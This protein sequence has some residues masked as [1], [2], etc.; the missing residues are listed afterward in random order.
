M[1]G[2]AF[3]DV[4]EELTAEQASFLVALR[5]RLAEGVRP[6]FAGV[7][8]DGMN[9]ILDVDA[10]DVVSVTVG[11]ALRGNQLKGDR[12]S[13]HHNGFPASPTGDGFLVEGST[14]E[15]ADR[16]A[17]LFERYWR[18]PVVLHAWLQDG[19]VY[20]S[21]YIFEDSGER[22]IQMY[23]SDWAPPGQEARLIGEEYVRGKGWRAARGSRLQPLGVGE[24]VDLPE[25]SLVVRPHAQDV[26]DSFLRQ[27]LV[28]QSV[29]D[30]DA[31]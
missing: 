26:D 21:C 3:F 5:R 14:E 6:Y 11:V 16:A 12:I 28:D 18:R 25:S 24:S 13:V 17:T 27:D 20:A 23:R 1:D 4:D 9:V 10:P 30:V 19:R 22:L 15:L 31:A 29:L 8:D 7:D 2:L